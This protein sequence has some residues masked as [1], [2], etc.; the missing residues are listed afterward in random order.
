MPSGANSTRGIVRRSTGGIPCGL[1]ASAGPP[2]VSRR[3][4]PASNSSGSNAI[5]QTPGEITSRAGLAVSGVTGRLRSEQAHPPKLRKLALMSVEHEVARK[6]PR[7]LENRA[8][9]LAQHHRIG[10]VVRYEGRSSAKDVEKH[11]VKVQAVH[12]VELG[13]VHKIDAHG[14]PDGDRDRLVDV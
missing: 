6:P 5:A 3:I 7:R 12:Q 13:D 4:S 14:T 2:R 8:L 9:P 1:S 10:V 11:P